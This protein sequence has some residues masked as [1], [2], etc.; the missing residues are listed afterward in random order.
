LAALGDAAGVS[1]FLG[2]LLIDKRGDRQGFP[3]GI[4]Q[5]LSRLQEHLLRSLQPNI[6]D[7]PDAIVP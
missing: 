7:G 5:E 6:G 2:E 1:A 4:A 3:G